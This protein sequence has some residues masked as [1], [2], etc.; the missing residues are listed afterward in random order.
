MSQES[1]HVRAQTLLGCRDLIQ[2]IFDLNQFEIKTYRFLTL[3]GPKSAEEIG[4]ILGKDRSTAYRALRQL[5][6]C[7][8]VYK[9][10]VSLEKGGYQH[11]YYAIEAEKVREE[12]E[13]LLEVWIKK[14]RQAVKS[15]PE[16]LKTS[17]ENEGV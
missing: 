11:M 6:S 9:K 5:L 3:E 8:I 1:L 16:D 12:I 2:C 4:K 7:R 15:F 17:L 13:A 14:M 10:T